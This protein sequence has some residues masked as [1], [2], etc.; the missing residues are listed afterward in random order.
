MRLAAAL[1]R[2]ELSSV[3]LTRALLDRI[4]RLDGARSFDGNPHHINAF[5]RVDAED[6]LAAAAAADRRR[7]ADPD[8]TPPLCGIPVALKDLIAVAG[9]S[10]TASSAVL[11]DAP[12]ADRDSDVWATLRAQGMVHLG[13]VHTHEFAAGGTTDQVGNPWDLARSAG[14][15]SGGSAAAVA[16]RLVPLSVGT[17]TMGSVR[18]PAA[19]T[20]TSAIKPTQ[21]AISTRGVIPLAPS[22]DDIGPMARTVADAALLLGALTGMDYPLTP[23]AG[24]RPLAGTRIAVTHRVAADRCDPDVLDGGQT[25][26]QAALR[27]GAEIVELEPG[28]APDAALAGTLIRYEMAAHHRAYRSRRDHYRPM[29]RDQLDAIGIGPTREEYEAARDRRRSL[30]QAWEG[31]FAEHDV[32]AVLEPTVVMTAPLRAVP[33]SSVQDDPVVHQHLSEYPALWNLTGQPAIAL[34]AGLGSRTGL[35]AGVSLTGSRNSETSL[36]PIALDLQAVL[37]VAGPPFI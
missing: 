21:G 19:L 32:D 29:V 8:N 11:A 13:H 33:G 27:L 17:D 35:P 30:R 9:R 14:G 7:A 6:A 12:P 26:V 24:R 31:W 3:E 20:G 15:S 34:P 28:P 23:R 16:A 2:R 36:V 1:R 5:V 37:G 25:A 18:I 4:E 22:L 10:V